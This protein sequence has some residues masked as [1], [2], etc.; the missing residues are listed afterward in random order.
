MS[1][2]PS[3]AAASVVIRYVKVPLQISRQIHTVV[4]TVLKKGIYNKIVC[5]YLILIYLSKK[6]LRR[7]LSF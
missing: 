4:K 1:V 5:L 2:A 6:Y 3:T 7:K